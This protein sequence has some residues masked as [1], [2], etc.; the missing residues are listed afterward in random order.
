MFQSQGQRSGCLEQGLPTW[1]AGPGGSHPLHPL[2]RLDHQKRY[3]DQT[4][5]L[6]VNLQG[7]ATMNITP[8][9]GLQSSTRGTGGTW[10]EPRRRGR[11]GRL[12]TRN[13]MSTGDTRAMKSPMTTTMDLD[14]AE[15][16]KGGEALRGGLHLHLHLVD[17]MASSKKSWSNKQWLCRF[18]RLAAPCQPKTPPIPSALHGG[19][20]VWGGGRPSCL[21]EL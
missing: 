12:S 18:W 6:I 10:R 14:M 7:L 13:I 1:K 4:L 19:G 2:V 8:C 11:L 9:M 5:H 21:Q 17:N 3:D 15:E 16:R 20:R